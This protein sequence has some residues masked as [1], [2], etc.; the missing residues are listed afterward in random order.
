M[1]YIYLQ[2]DIRVSSKLTVNA[3]L[4]YELVTPQWE[5][6][7]LLSNY[8]PDTQS[9]IQAKSGSLYN[10]SLVHIPKLDFA[11]RIGFAYSVDPKTVIR[12]GYGINYAQFNREGGENLLVYNLPAIVNTNIVQ[13]PQFT[14]ASVAG[15]QAGLPVCTADQVSI[16]YSPA[17]PTP[18]FRTSYQGYPTGL[19]SPANVTAKSTLTA[20]AR[21]IPKNLPTGYV[22]GYHLTVQRQVGPS[23]T[24][25][26]S[27]V[28]EHGVKLQ[29][30][31]DLNQ[32]ASNAVTATC[33][34]HGHVRLPHAC[35]ASTHPDVHHH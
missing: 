15:K 13:A 19:T 12:A 5:R 10:R 33:N 24:V 22:Q 30:L 9:L 20:Q 29:V 7:N 34:P 17:D 23:T 1:H 6:N 25:E 27:Y 8:D 35:P 31:A 3:G 11:P 28:G 2:D 32:S 21:Y 14:A 18:C 4:R 26:V 16:P